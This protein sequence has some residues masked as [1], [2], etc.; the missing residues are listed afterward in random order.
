M[1]KDP[2]GGISISALELE[3]GLSKDSLRTWERR[4][5]F[6][7][8]YR[9]AWGERR[10]PLDQ[11]DKLRLIRR[12][13]N[14]G[15]RPGSIIDRSI[16]E[17]LELAVGK[18]TDAR[19][20][21]CFDAEFDAL[22]QAIREQNIASLRAGLRGQLVRLGV[23]PFLTEF[24]AVLNAVV[25]NAWARDELSVADEHFYTE[26]V[27]VVLRAATHDLRAEAESPK[28]LLTTVPGEQHRL[29]LQ[30]L[31]ALLVSERVECVSLGTQT[32]LNEIVAAATAGRVDIVALSFSGAFPAKRALDSLVELRNALPAPV[33]IWAGGAG[34]RSIRKKIA[35]IVM[36]MTLSSVLPEV[37]QWRSEAR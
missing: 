9:D 28:I 2:D 20:S 32:P 24:V 36:A 29:G 4:Y 3:S 30:M 5:G 14:A 13:M 12:L 17:L 10:Y 26:Q 19:S 27:E 21:G 25:G 7:Q 23:Q 18:G 6:P 37:R 8:P 11:V 34:V 31:E 35:G 15:F 1:L 33:S 16:E 22:V